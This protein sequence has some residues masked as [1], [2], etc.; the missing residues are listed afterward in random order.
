MKCVPESQHSYVPVRE[1]CKQ[2]GEGG[3]KVIVKFIRKGRHFQ[4][5]Q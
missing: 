5:F 1:E 2:G 4:Y 3:V